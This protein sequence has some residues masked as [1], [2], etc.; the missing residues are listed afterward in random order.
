MGW[1]KE[2]SEVHAGGSDRVG[3]ARGTQGVRLTISVD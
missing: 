1:E 2:G 3:M